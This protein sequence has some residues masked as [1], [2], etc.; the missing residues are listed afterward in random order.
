MSRDMEVFVPSARIKEAGKIKVIRGSGWA[1]AN[2]RGGW[3]SLSYGNG[4][5]Q[6]GELMSGFTFW[7]Y[8]WFKGGYTGRRYRCR[9]RDWCWCLRNR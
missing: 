2:I 6:G 9:S 1:W 4:R 3:N 8:I 5:G 7:W